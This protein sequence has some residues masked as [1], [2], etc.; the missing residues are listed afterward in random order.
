PGFW[1]C[2]S[3]SGPSLS[4]GTWG[5]AGRKLKI[6]S[7]RSIKR[8][9][10]TEAATPEILSRPDISDPHGFVA[11][12]EIEKSGFVPALWERSLRLER[13]CYRPYTKLAAGPRLPTRSDWLRRRQ[14]S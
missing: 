8:R 4:A 14:L 9:P 3:S 13:F 2:S 7:P 11:F 1:S 10:E 12:M 5:E 6:R